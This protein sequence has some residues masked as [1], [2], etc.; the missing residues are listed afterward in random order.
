MKRLIAQEE[1]RKQRLRAE[2]EAARRAQE[3]AKREADERRRRDLEGRRQALAKKKAAL[4]EKNSI[5]E[6]SEPAIALCCRTKSFSHADEIIQRRTLTRR[7]LRLLHDAV[8][9]C[10]LAKARQTSSPDS[11]VAPATV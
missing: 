5:M 1:G 7:K 6:V 4:R 8:C 3:L 2:E 11:E 10:K 9:R